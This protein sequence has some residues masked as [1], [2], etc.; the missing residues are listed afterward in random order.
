MPARKVLIS[1][2]GGGPLRFL[3][4]TLPAAIMAVPYAQNVASFISAGTPPYTE[5]LVSKTGADPWT[6]NAGGTIQGTPLA[7]NVLITNDGFYLVTATGD[8]FGV[9]P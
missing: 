5:S 4:A 3:G 9:E 8:V 6:V 1:P 2:A 7:P